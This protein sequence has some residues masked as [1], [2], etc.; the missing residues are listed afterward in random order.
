[1]LSGKYKLVNGFRTSVS[2]QFCPVV[3]DHYLWLS[4]YYSFPKFQRSQFEHRKRIVAQTSIQRH[5]TSLAF[6]CWW[7]SC[8]SKVF[9][10]SIYPPSV[11]SCMFRSFCSIWRTKYSLFPTWYRFSSYVVSVES[12]FGTEGLK[13]IQWMLQSLTLVLLSRVL[14][15]SV[16]T[17]MMMYKFFSCFY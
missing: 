17:M 11:L 3:C 9:F 2:C 10:I 12:G 8:F 14:V 16:S 13:A 6:V 7:R 15:F 5:L 4:C 1:M